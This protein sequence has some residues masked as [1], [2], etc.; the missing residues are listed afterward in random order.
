[1]TGNFDN[2]SFGT[3]GIVVSNGSLTISG[4]DVSGNQGAGVRLVGGRLAVSDT[5]ISKNWSG[6]S[7]HNSNTYI[8]N[9]TISEGSSGISAFDS[10]LSISDSAI[11]NNRFPMSHGTLTILPGGGIDALFTSM[12]IVRSTITGNRSMRQNSGGISTRG[13]SSLDITESVISD[14]E[15]QFGAGIQIQGG[16]TSILNTSISN[17]KID[18]RFT[19]NNGAGID[20]LG[21]SFTIRNSEIRGNLGGVGLHIR[22]EQALI[23]DSAITDNSYSGIWLEGINSTITDCTISG[24][25]SSGILARSL[26]T[27]ISDTILEGNTA[28]NGGGLNASDGTTIIQRCTI[29]GN[30]AS[31]GGGVFLYGGQTIITDTLIHANQKRGATNLGRGG[32]ISNYRNSTTIINSTISSNSVFGWGGGISNDGGTLTL[33]RS[34]VIANTAERQGGGIY[35]FGT[36][37]VTDCTIANNSADSGGGHAGNGTF[38]R[39]TIA[40]NIAHGEN[41]LTNTSGNGGG[42]LGSGIRVI[43]STIE[44]NQARNAGGGIASKFSTIRQSTI[45]GNSA[46]IGGGLFLSYRNQLDHCT[47]AFNHA[48]TIG[49]GIFFTGIDSTLSHTIVGKNSIS[50]G[51]GREIGGA[52]GGVINVRN[53][54]IEYAFGSGLT[55]SPDGMPDANGNLIGGITQIDPMLAP[56]AL[57]GGPTKT[58][59]L[60]PGS[61]A[62]NMGDLAATAGVGGVPPFDQRGVP[63]TRVHGGRIDIGA[64]ELQ[65]NP[66]T[67][68]YNFNGVVDAADYSLWRNARNLPFDLRADGNVDG[69]VDDADYEVWRANFG[70][71]LPVEA[72]A[73]VEAQKNSDNTSRS[74]K[75]FD[76]LDEVFE[77]IG[78]QISNRAGNRMHLL[79]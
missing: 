6:I 73:A 63:F 54:L 38:L 29:T 44:G 9:S 69:I 61:P 50:F 4:C 35:S 46:V 15:S 24:H 59:A 27:T 21:A 41:H 49:G 70:R 76:S 77:L 58:H 26:M 31:S 34:Q 55:P 32:G 68:D 53:S 30:S 65:P 51:P 1:V 48:N 52:I 56:L 18:P 47:I 2:I 11:A 66:L 37:N 28:R 71:T 20:C 36:L 43:D 39:T 78:S 67:G 25:S 45:S 79:E 13:S 19:S 5:K 12:T 40:G 72:V 8:D 62:I 75:C 64:F 7:V 42:I 23:E 57:N 17:N 3:Y 33:N 22:A 74:H 14:N 16:H 10:D 60:L